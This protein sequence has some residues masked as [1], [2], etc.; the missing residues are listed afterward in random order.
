MKKIVAEK[1]D[2][3]AE[4]VDQMLNEPDNDVTIVIPRGSVLVR[5]M[6]NFRLLK[7]EA[8]AAGKEVA[9]ESVDETALAF[10]KECG[11]EA[12]HP[13][14]RGVR[15]EHGSGNG[16]SDI[17]PKAHHAPA[18]SIKKKK[19]AEPEPEP[20]PEEE[21]VMEDEEEEEMPAAHHHARAA[22]PARRL[23]LREEEEGDEE[24][25]VRE[26]D[27]EDDETTVEDD[28][29]GKEGVGNRF[30]KSAPF[31]SSSPRGG[32][33]PV[34]RD[35]DDDDDDNRPRRRI[36]GRTWTIVVILVLI[37]LGGAYVASA[38]FNHANISISFKKT[39]W[40]WQG[41]LTA[42]KAASQ[43]DLANGVLAAQVFT[44]NKN[45][46]D[47][48]KASGQSDVSLKAT[49]MITIYNDYSTKPQELVA[50]TRFLTPDGKIFRIT[51]NVTVPGATKVADGSLQ[52]SSIT[53]PIVADQAG[54]A[55]NIG[56]VAKLTIPG[57]QKDPQ[58]SGF[59]GTINAS[60]TGGYTGQRAVPTQ[61]DIAAAK[62]ST[63]AD[64]QA[65]LQGG[66]SGTY[67]N[68]FKILDGATKVNVGTLTVNTTTDDNGNFTVFATA[69][70]S[71]IGFDE[72]ALKDA[73][74]AQAQATEA[75]STFADVNL[76][77]SNVSADFTKGQV[78]FSLAVQADL[79]PAFMP[80][81]FEQEILGKSVADARTAISTLPQL[82]HA[83]ISVWPV[84]LST[85][86][87]NPAKVKIAEN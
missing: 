26:A 45:V 8:E 12:V 4:I 69:T 33:G 2:G 73:L 20:E 83:E 58:Y 55:Y 11:I 63:T 39:P 41:N 18:V 64:L 30:F 72:S 29:V 68:N 9:V 56:P 77:Y 57:F 65:S 62:A 24:A 37:G 61:A 54:P 84:W 80:V 60:T 19:A 75:S 27:A 79:E 3:I 35:Y 42:D 40:T 14:W 43:D 66:F 71:A 81:D 70:L 78:S 67:P 44:A 50:T 23:S 1:E 25:D 21:S 49:G 86:P 6:S 46:T 74:L 34:R 51:K 38:Y 82:S 48:F 31:F 22:S 5:T 47:S 17:V 15:S 36:G 87:S 76:N 32:N 13:L 28:D 10:A 53:A 16:M 52:A 59:W 7:R 85:I